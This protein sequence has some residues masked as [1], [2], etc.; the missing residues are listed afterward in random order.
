[1]RCGM[2]ADEA[3]TIR[4][5]VTAS[6]IASEKNSEEKM[7]NLNLPE[8]FAEGLAKAL[9]DRVHAPDDIMIAASHELRG[10]IVDLLEQRVIEI[11]YEGL[12]YP[13]RISFPKREE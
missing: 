5:L 11:D 7:M 4:N 1:M 9:A 3:L 8:R 12:P 10:I 2:N 6:V 13:I